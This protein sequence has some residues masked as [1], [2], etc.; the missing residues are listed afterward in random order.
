MHNT[1]DGPKTFLSS[2]GPASPSRLLPTDFHVRGCL[3]FMSVP[4]R[5]PYLCSGDHVLQPIHLYVSPKT[6]MRSRY[7]AG[8]YPPN[9]RPPAFGSLVYQHL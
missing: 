4:V 6:S 3:Q 7:M 2:K 5:F 1:F 8:W 9:A